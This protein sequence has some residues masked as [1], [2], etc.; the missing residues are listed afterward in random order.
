[1]TEINAQKVFIINI[2]ADADDRVFNPIF[3]DNNQIIRIPFLCQNN[4]IS[5]EALNYLFK[6]LN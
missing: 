3:S 2:L 6:E 1:M 5:Q 4:K